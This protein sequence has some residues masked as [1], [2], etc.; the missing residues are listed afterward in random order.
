MKAR[1]PHAWVYLLKHEAALRSRERGAFDDD[2]W[3]RFGRNQN[4][5]KQERVKLGVAQT[6][7]GMRV[8]ADVDGEFYFN[9]VRVNAILPNRADDLFFLLGVLNSK[10]IDAVFRR[11]AKPKGGGYFEAN[12]QFI[13]PLPIPA[14]D[15]AQKA[16]VGRRAKHLQD[17]HTARR[18]AV[19]E[20]QRRLDSTQCVDGAREESWLWGD[21]EPSLIAREAPSECVGRE[22]KAWVKTT[23]IG[24]VDAHLGSVGSSLRPGARFSVEN[25]EGEV[26]FLADGA[27]LLTVYEDQDETPLVAAQWRLVA[28]TLRVGEGF[29]PASLVRAL[30]GLRT[31]QNISLR[32]QV[33]DLD[34]RI[35]AFDAEIRQSEEELNKYTYV[36]YGLAESEIRL[37]ES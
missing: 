20:L 28:R 37:V 36:L 5:D 2:E 6:V 19:R 4:I 35:V 7:P 26:R 12:K 16:E 24:R 10:V 33:V 9:N 1:F 25:R 30:L 17:L 34:A 27:P 13:A 31:T 15:A 18:N 22:L 23:R 32:A 8:F 29:R 14:A 21:V 3:Y 11:I